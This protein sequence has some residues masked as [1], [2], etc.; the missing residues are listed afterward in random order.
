MSI[1]RQPPRRYSRQ[2]KFPRTTP[3]NSATS[4]E[5]EVTESMNIEQ[6]VMDPEAQ[7]FDSIANKYMWDMET[8]DET[9]SSMTSRDNANKKRILTF[10]YI[11][12][13]AAFIFGVLLAYTT[14]YSG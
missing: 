11:A 10:C 9:L 3:R 6:P 8:E 12:T 7:K 4:D 14:F 13:F 1:S 5:L 2:M